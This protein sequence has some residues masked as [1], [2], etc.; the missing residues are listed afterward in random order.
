MVTEFTKKP[1][2]VQAVQWRGDNEAEV[3]E[4]T[5]RTHFRQTS[6]HSDPEITAEVRDVLH[7]TWVGVKAG[8]WVIRGVAGE[9]YP[10]DQQVLTA[11]YDEVT[12]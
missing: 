3:R 12:T 2:T 1:V 6:S 10:I 5:G 4:L 8:Q 9:F 7:S 11:T